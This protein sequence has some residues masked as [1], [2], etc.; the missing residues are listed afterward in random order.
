[1]YFPLGEGAEQS[2][3]YRSHPG[4]RIRP[5]YRDQSRNWLNELPGDWGVPGIVL[6]LDSTL[7]RMD[8][9]LENAD[10][11][12]GEVF[13][14]ADIIALPLVDRMEDLGFSAS[15]KGKF[16]KSANWLERS[17][18]RASFETAFYPKSRLSEF[19]PLAP[20]RLS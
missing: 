7:A 8:T 10:W 19:L 15:W 12:S 3:R 18:D 2:H 13:G 1:M 6:Q 20:L 4:R 9:R 5:G 16:K 11:L 17:M 14:L